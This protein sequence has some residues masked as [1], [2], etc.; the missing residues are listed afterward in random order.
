[1]HL[2]TG[3]GN[4]TVPQVVAAALAPCPFAFMATPS[5]GR[6]AARKASSRGLQSSKLTP[7]W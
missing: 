2:A 6:A 7:G 4:F 3:R 1:M 5:Y